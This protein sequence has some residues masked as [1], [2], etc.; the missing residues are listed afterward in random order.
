[1]KKILLIAIFSLSNLAFAKINI[2]VSIKP[3]HSIISNLTQGVA[4]PKLLLQNNQSAHHFHLSP[5]QISL[6]SNADLI[7][8][9]HPEFETGLAKSLRQIAQNKQIIINSATQH[10]RHSWLDIADMQALSKII[11]RKLRQIDP[12]NSKIYQKNLQL[13]M[14]KLAKLKRE[15][16]EKLSNYQHSKVA[17][18]SNAIAPFLLSNNLQSPITV[19]KTHNDRLSIYKISSA[20]QLMKKQKT[21]CLLS[22]IEIP[23]KRINTLTEIANINSARIDI[24]GTNVRQGAG[25]YFQLMRAIAGQVV[26]CLR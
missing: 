21:S 23:Q 20:Q 2:V 25:Q 8:S 7:I 19:T 5:K 26:Q 11:S 24:I 9:L 14:Q 17:I 22:T 18:F 6:I 16:A 3:L 12:E 13:T 15:N 4:K 10:K 1:M